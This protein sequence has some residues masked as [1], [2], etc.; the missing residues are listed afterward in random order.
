MAEDG[1]RG[2][3]TGGRLISCSRWAVADV[4]GELAKTKLILSQVTNMKKKKKKRVGRRKVGVR[5]RK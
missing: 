4:E 3:G 5:G 1:G 2:G